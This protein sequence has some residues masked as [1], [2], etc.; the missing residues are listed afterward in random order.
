MNKQVKNCYESIAAQAGLA[1][2]LTCSVIHGKR[3]GFD[4]TLFAPNTSYPYMLQ[5][6]V[7][8]LRPAGVLTNDELR[9]LRR[10]HKSIRAVRQKGS[11]LAVSLK[12]SM[13]P[14][15]VAEN[16]VASVGLVLAFLR[17]HGFYN[18]C[19]MC[20]KPGQADG[21]VVGGEV[22]NL[23]P[24]CYALVQQG[25]QME[26][27]KLA[28]TREN[29][30]AGIVGALLGSLAGVVCIIVLS[31]L[32]YISVISGLVMALC[33]LKGYELLGGKLTKVGAT[34]TFVLMLIMTY[35]GDRIDW[36]IVI[37]RELGW[38]F[39]ESFLSVG[40]LMQMGA[41]DAGA[42]WGNLVLLYVF[43]IVGAVPIMLGSLRKRRAA[44][45]AY[46]LGDGVQPRA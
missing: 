17:T 45:V 34:V 22:M 39:G 29:V 26:S 30:P 10:A 28:N 41:L 21:C 13:W 5:I 16:A 6:Q 7:S 14:K 19:Q 37:A 44:T 1:V 43:L 15:K 31:Q 25:K 4:V 40:D 8:A 27:E 2:D 18:A 23:C 24:A 32:G 42:Y 33:A 3:D 46:H 38:G 36:A 11:V 20:G 35:V 9:E 12:Q